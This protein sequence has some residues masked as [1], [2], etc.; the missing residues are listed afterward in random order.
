MKKWGI[1]M[2][3]TKGI[4]I[5]Q[6]DFGEQNRMLT[7]FTEDYGLVKAAIYGVKKGKS[8]QSAASQFLSY[9]EFMLHFGRG[10]VA[11]VNSIT[12]IESFFPIA[13]DLEKLALSSYLAELT[14]YSQNL[15]VPN[16]VILRLILNTLYLVAYKNYPIKKA[17]AIYELRIVKDM[18]Y[19]PHIL[20]CLACGKKEDL[21]GFS[22]EKEGVLCADCG[23]ITKDTIKLGKE[24]YSCMGY[25]L[26]ADDNKVFSFDISPEAQKE[27]SAIS[28]R[29]ILKCAEREFSSLNYLKNVLT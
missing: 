24:A 1:F 15:N 19:M 14:Y 11:N 2:E 25:I 3:K 29:Y 17:K 5:K 22:L 13:E 21:S 9:G 8:K 6:A 20:N 4:V 16:P 7:I 26:Y 18:G 27:L 12:P 23:R 28:E 10:E